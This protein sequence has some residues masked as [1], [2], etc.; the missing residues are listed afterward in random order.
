MEGGQRGTMT[1]GPMDFG[2]PMSS[3][4]THPNFGGNLF[5]LEIT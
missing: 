3:K 5:F 1:S 2:G 4:G